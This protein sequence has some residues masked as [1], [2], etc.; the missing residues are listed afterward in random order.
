MTETDRQNNI[1]LNTPGSAIS[2]A[3]GIFPFC[4]ITFLITLSILACNK[5]KE[6]TAPAIHPRDSVAMMTSYGIN[7]LISDSGVMKYRIVA[8]RWDVNENVNP[9]RWIFPRGLFLEQFDEKFHVEAY[10]QSDTAYYFTVQKLWHL[11]GNVRI[12]TVDGVRYS[13]EEIYWDQQKHELY[14]NKFSHLITPQ[15]EMQGSYFRSD[16]NMRHYFVSNSKG[17]FVKS[18]MIKE[19]TTSTTADTPESNTPKRNPTNPHR[20]TK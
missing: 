11:I 16:E 6:H 7:T 13:S 17:S 12:R 3:F 9:P 2:G 14:S 19:D 4:F 5:P 8:E 15:R 20:S 10:I 18:D 1:A